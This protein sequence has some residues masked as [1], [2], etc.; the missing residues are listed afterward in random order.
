MKTL[1]RMKLLALAALCSVFLTGCLDILG[2]GWLW[3]ANG[4]DAG[5]ATF[6]FDFDCDSGSNTAGGHMT[7]HDQGVRVNE[8]P[9]LSQG[10]EWRGKPKILAIQGEV[11]STLIVPCDADGVYFAGYF[12]HYE[13]IPPSIGEGGVFE[14]TASDGGDTG[15]DKGDHLQI[16]ILTGV[17][18]GYQ[19]EGS[20]GGGNISLP[21]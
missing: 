10:A 14:V 15:P 3:S 4:E 7:Y 1:Q 6:G 16:A 9:Y 5:R 19:N 2:G 8:E 13:P 20:P 17:F 11:F 21:D 18:A 12:G